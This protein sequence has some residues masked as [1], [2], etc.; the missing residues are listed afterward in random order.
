MR[1]Y[2]IKK[3]EKNLKIKKK[4]IWMKVCEHVQ[5]SNETSNRKTHAITGK[6]GPLV[7]QTLYAPEQGN[8]R[9]ERWESVGRGAGRGGGGVYRELLG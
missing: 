1:K 9:A 5:L 7:L 8:A 6:S 2:L 3:K 4:V